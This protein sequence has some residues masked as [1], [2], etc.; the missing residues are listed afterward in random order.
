MLAKNIV[1]EKET[2]LKE[3][4]KMM[5]TLL[6]CF[7]L[8]LSAFCPVYF[9]VVTTCL[10]GL[11]ELVH[12]TGWFISSLILMTTTVF[13][14]TLIL[15]GGRVFEFSSPLLIFIYLEVSA[16]ASIMVAFIISTLF[17]KARIAAAVAGMLCT[18]CCCELAFVPSPLPHNQAC[19]HPSLHRCCPAPALTVLLLDF[20]TYLPFVFVAI[21]EETLGATSKWAASLLSTTAFGIGASYIAR[22]EEIGE[23]IQFNN[24]ASGVG[25]CDNFSFA[26]ALFMMV[27]DCFLYAIFVW[28]LEQV[29]TP[30]GIPKPWHFPFHR[31]FW[32]QVCT[33]QR[34]VT[35]QAD[36]RKCV[37]DAHSPDP[38]EGGAMHGH[39]EEL[40]LGQSVGVRFEGLTKVYRAEGC[41]DQGE[42]VA[43]DNLNFEMT[44][45][46]ITGLLGHNGAVSC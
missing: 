43:V 38:K 37:T 36:P 10:T 15:I 13:L 28:Y 14:M 12:W 11:T 26:A 32:Q 9:R 24:M 6:D 39:Y 8:R 44:T 19:L 21:R 25:P 30:Y 18:S 29:L 4:T 45:P 46:G 17:S 31:T 5:G 35:R 42:R 34:T 22:Y 23:G 40:P 2:R 16:I 7:M 3:F 1:H 27:V 41:T 20:G 33:R